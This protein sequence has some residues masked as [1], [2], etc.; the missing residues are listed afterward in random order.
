MLIIALAF[1]GAASLKH[2][3]LH[4]IEVFEQLTDSTTNI[5]KHKIVLQPRQ[6]AACS[7]FSLHVV[8]E[9]I[10]IVVDLSARRIFVH[11]AEPG[12]QEFKNR[13]VHALRGNSCD[14]EFPSKF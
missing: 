1:V 14:Q 6:S 9:N 4:R 11:R 7:S 2:I 12:R 10:A 8:E 5:V 13:L 3:V